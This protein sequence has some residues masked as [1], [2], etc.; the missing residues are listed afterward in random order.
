MSKGDKAKELFLNG[1]NCS[2]AVFGAFCEDFGVDFDTAASLSAGFGGGIGRLRET[3]GA[4][5]GAVL[6]I[7]LAMGK[8]KVENPA[9][10][11]A[12]YEKIRQLVANFEAETGSIIC[13]DMLGVKRRGDSPDAEPRTPE[14]Y[15]KRP[16]AD[17]VYL[18][19][20][21]AEKIISEMQ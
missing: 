5:S 6:A 14:Y 11:T 7:S 19:A 21:S 8:F 2:Q 9:A 15:K 13:A 4:V 1:Y 18:A 12:V 3:C 10:K 16:C 17:L 20:E